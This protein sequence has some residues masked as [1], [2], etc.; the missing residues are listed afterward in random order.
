MAETVKKKP[1]PIPTSAANAEAK[2]G[3]DPTKKTKVDAPIVG[4]SNLPVVKL[5]LLVIGML[6][7]MVV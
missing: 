3:G 7:L 2:L 1:K 6:F 4:E 5:V